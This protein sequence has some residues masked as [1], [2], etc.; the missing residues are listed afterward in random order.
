M[1][2]EDAARLAEIDVRLSREHDPRGDN[3]Y[4]NERFLRRLLHEAEAERDVLKEERDQLETWRDYAAH[5]SQA[6]RDRREDAYEKNGR[7]GTTR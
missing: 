3:R 7:R 1:T 4:S 2:P 6:I 5:V